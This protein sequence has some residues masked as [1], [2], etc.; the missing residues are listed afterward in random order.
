[1]HHLFQCYLRTFW[2]ANCQPPNLSGRPIFPQSTPFGC[3][4]SLNQ[5][6]AM[7]APS[8]LPPPPSRCSVTGSS[9]TTVRPGASGAARGSAA[10]VS[11][12]AQGA[13]RPVPAGRESWQGRLAPNHQPAHVRVTV[14]VNIVIVDHTP[15]MLHRDVIEDASAPMRARERQEPMCGR[16][17]VR[18]HNGLGL[19]AHRPNGAMLGKITTRVHRDFPTSNNDFS[20]RVLTSPPH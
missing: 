7:P 10:L 6:W 18:E 19:A 4:P 15:Q 17:Q 16:E 20:L 8:S 1:M 2:A 5:P 11:G 3:T 9:P 12:P 14:A 13:R